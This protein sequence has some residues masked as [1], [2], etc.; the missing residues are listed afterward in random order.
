MQKVTKL[1]TGFSNLCN[2]NSTKLA[3]VF[4]LH[5]NCVMNRTNASL[6]LQGCIWIQKSFSHLVLENVR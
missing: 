6:L 5:K 3:W 4:P 2:C 1:E